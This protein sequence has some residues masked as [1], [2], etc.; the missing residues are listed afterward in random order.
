MNKELL[1]MLPQ[2]DSVIGEALKNLTESNKREKGQLEERKIDLSLLTHI[3]RV[4]IDKV[5]QSIL[6]GGIGDEISG[7]A[8]E[9]NA[10]SL[11]KRIISD[12]IDKYGDDSTP[13]LRRVINATGLTLHTNLGRAVLSHKAA[14]AA[15]DVATTYS[16]LEYDI[17]S[18]N[19]GIRYQNVEEMICRI[20]GKESALVVNNN[21]AAVMLILHALGYN[22]NMIISRGEL[23]EIGGSFRIPAVMEISGVTLKEVGCTN[24]TY[25]EDYEDAIDDNTAAVLKVHASNFAILGF[26]HTVE[27]EE[28]SKLTEK[29]NIPLIYDMGSGSVDE[30]KNCTTGANISCVSG[31]K[32]L[33]G[34]QCGIIF[35]DKLYLDLIKKDNLLRALRVDKMTLAALEETLREYLTNC[36]SDIPVNI[37]LNRTI[38]DMRMI[39]DGI[40]RESGV[41]AIKPIKISCVTVDSYT[42]GGS[43]PQEKIQN[44]CMKIEHESLS[45]TKLS[46]IFRKN[47][48]PIIGRIHDGAFLLDMRCLFFEDIDE[49]ASVIKY[50]ATNTENAHE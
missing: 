11:R 19:R 7:E 2:V 17:E 9:K 16:N 48:I 14:Q 44:L 20:T 18:G 29:N 28:L 42:G 27:L 31:D 24:K 25:L 30:L 50:F 45:A 41:E 4:E 47:R 36:E 6:D 39:Y 26:T 35:G 43:H 33:G 34:P 1:K 38:E 13:K 46:E 21:A 49:I 15:Y 3:A 5:R 10:E 40:C 23:V 12:V 8:D 22:K 37:F 32:L